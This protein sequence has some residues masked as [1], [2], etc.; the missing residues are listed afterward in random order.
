M[1]VQDYGAAASHRQHFHELV[2]EINPERQSAD[3]RPARDRI[4]GP[5]HERA[6]RN[7]SS[8]GQRH[9]QDDEQDVHVRDSFHDGRDDAHGTKNERR[10]VAVIIKLMALPP[11]GIGR[12]ALLRAISYRIMSPLSSGVTQPRLGQEAS[13]LVVMNR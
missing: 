4:A 10:Q 13:P 1:L 12:F 9:E 6:A 11:L 7:G 8:E 3:R 5:L 2:K